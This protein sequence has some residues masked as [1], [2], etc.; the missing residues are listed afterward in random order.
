[1]GNCRRKK[2]CTSYSMN[3]NIPA[4]ARMTMKAARTTTSHASFV[5]NRN[6]TRSTGGWTRD[7]GYKLEGMRTFPFLDFVSSFSK[8]QEKVDIVCNYVLYELIIVENFTMKLHMDASSLFEISIDIPSS[9]KEGFKYLL[10]HSD[11]FYITF[12]VHIAVP[13]IRRFC[14]ESMKWKCD[15]RYSCRCLLV[16]SD[17]SKTKHV[18][19]VQGI[20]WNY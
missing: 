10:N 2:W 11:S 13:K 17:A 6:A 12:I 3:T 14:Q 7:R 18:L 1:M 20:R 9:L 5:W 16:K 15:G 8:R 19:S 4:S